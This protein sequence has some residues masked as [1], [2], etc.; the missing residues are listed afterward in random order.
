M[1]I[2]KTTNLING[3]IYIGQ[4]SNN[5][6]KYFGSGFLI[7]KAIKKYGLENFKKEIIE[8]C[9]SK[10]ILNDREKFWIKFFNSTDKNIGY[11]ISEGGTGGKLVPFEGKKGKTY[12]EYY[13]I[14]RANEIKQKL[15]EK[16]KG[17]KPPLKNIT[18]EEVGK[19]ISE[20]LK[21]K[22]I[23][24]DRKKKVSKTLKDYFKTEEGLKQIKKFSEDRKGFKQSEDSNIKRSNT[25]KGKRPKILDVHPSAKYW[26]FYDKE[27]NLILETLGNRT[28]KLK[29]L[30]TNQRRIVIFDNLDECLSYDLPNNKDFKIFTKKYYIKDND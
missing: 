21:G 18:I 19:K 16:R 14:E 2:Y 26:Y 5:D 29:E 24:E 3:K 15:S 27:N 1:V 7:T 13:G 11:N 8:E 6:E 9:P 22:I 28:K 12:E 23:S 20:S 17:Y 25:L 10:D 30:G 4:N